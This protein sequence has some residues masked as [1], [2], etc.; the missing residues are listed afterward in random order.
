MI[1]KVP[2]AVSKLSV[3]MAVGSG[4]G[5]GLFLASEDG[6]QD[7][8]AVS[9]WMDLAVGTFITCLASLGIIKILF[10]GRVLHWPGMKGSRARDSGQGTRP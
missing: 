10:P 9:P 1:S 4:G 5:L 7:D 6:Q 8:P 3:V 2:G